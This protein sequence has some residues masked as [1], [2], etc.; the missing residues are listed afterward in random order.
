MAFAL[1]KTPV[2]Q[3]LFT[4][5][6]RGKETLM[7]ARFPEKGRYTRPAGKQPDPALE[8]KEFS[9]RVNMNYLTKGMVCA[10]MDKNGNL[11]PNKVEELDNLRERMFEGEGEEKEEAFREFVNKMN[12]PEEKRADFEI[13]LKANMAEG[14]PLLLNTAFTQPPPGR[15]E[16]ARAERLCLT[17][18]LSDDSIYRIKQ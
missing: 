15:R 8:G 18:R 5:E 2:G 12:V 16:S 11:Y 1:K 3:E 9:I 13:F 17:N 4:F 6:E 7:Q 10:C 14:A